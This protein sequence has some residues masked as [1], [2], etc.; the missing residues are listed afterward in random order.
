MSANFKKTILVIVGVLGI[1]LVFLFAFEKS[2]DEKNR[3]SQS[4]EAVILE[5]KTEIELPAPSGKTSDILSGAL[6]AVEAEKIL[7]DKEDA[8]AEDTLEDEGDV[9]AFSNAYEDTNF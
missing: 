3:E 8:L 6:Q 4:G 5:D 1:V 9:S 2:A 7:D